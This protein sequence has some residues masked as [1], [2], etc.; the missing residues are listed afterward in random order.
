VRDQWFARQGQ[1]ALV[2]AI[3]TPALA[4]G[5]NCGSNFSVIEW[6]D[7]SHFNLSIEYACT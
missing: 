3:H 4:T 7:S 2:L 5:E 1:K 6:V